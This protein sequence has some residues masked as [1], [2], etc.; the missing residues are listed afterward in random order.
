[1]AGRL[2]GALSADPPRSLLLYVCLPLIA[3]S[4]FGTLIVAA[5]L[6]PQPYDWRRGAISLLLYPAYDP[7]LHY[8]ASIGIAISGLLILPWTIY[9]RR[10]LHRIS[11]LVADVGALGLGLGALGLVLAGVVVSHPLHGRAAFPHLH[12]VLARGAALGLGIGI[13]AFWG[14]AAKA[15]LETATRRIEWRRLLVCWSVIALPALSIALLR[16]AVGVHFDWS[17][18]IYQRLQDRELWRVAVWEWLGSAAVFLF[19]LSALLYL[20][21][22]DSQQ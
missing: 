9:I 17:N 18:P 3:L 12:E 14:C 15:Y 20:P 22:L 19:L 7:R 10:R 2:R 6:S 11:T 5:R 13:V 16:I 1:M 8:V 21:E 4:Y